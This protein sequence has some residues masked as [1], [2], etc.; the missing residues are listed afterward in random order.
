LDIEAG[1]IADKARA[2]FAG[3]TVIV[4]SGRGGVHVWVRSKLRCIGGALAPGIADLQATGQLIIVPP[5]PGYGH[6]AHFTPTAEFIEANTIEVEDV[7]QWALAV[8]R[9][10]GVKPEHLQKA[11]WE[12]LQGPEIVAEA[13]NQV[14]AS[15]AGKLK[16]RLRLHPANIEAM[17]RG[18]YEHRMPHEGFDPDEEIPKMVHQAATWDSKY[19]SGEYVYLGE[20]QTEPPPATW[21]WNEIVYENFLTLF[22]GLGGTG[23]TELLHWLCYHMLLGKPCL[24]IKTQKLNNVIWW[25]YEVDL[26]EFTRRSF[27][28]ARALGLKEPPPGIHYFRGRQPAT[29]PQAQED[30]LDM[31]DETGADFLVLDSVFRAIGGDPL[32]ERGLIT[33]LF[34]FLDGLPIPVGVIDHSAQPQFGQ[35]IKTVH[36]YGFGGKT[37]TSRN[38][39]QIV[40]QDEGSGPTMMAGFMRRDKN[41]CG[42]PNNVEIPFLM[43]GL[44]TPAVEI[45][46][47]GEPTEGKSIRAQVLAIIEREARPLT[48]GELQRDHIHGHQQN[49]IRDACDESVDAGQLSVRRGT[50]TKP[51]RYAPLKY[52]WDKE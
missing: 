49:S 25:D 36:A 46:A 21:L 51:N 44:T 7:G 38:A 16:E 10:L 1:P 6:A 52:N 24:G 23:K 39:W 30:I 28:Y 3:K 37:W 18:L 41:N 9:K 26:R 2:M 40:R 17:L 29:L 33:N 19:N 27:R 15:T 22:Y 43:Q 14:L 13:R 45:I 35:S 12:S 8:L 20:G 4:D 34:V 32:E 5:T 48:A 31:I 42:L 11:S 50:G 47:R